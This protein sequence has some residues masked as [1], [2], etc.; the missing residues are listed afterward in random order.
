[1]IFNATKIAAGTSLLGAGGLAGVLLAPKPAE[2]ER[3]AGAL[4]A[5]A[6]VVR[7]VHIK[8]VHHRVIHEKPKRVHHAAPAAPAPAPVAA[9]TAAPA[10]IRPV[11]PAPAPAPTRQPLRTRTSGSA[12]TGESE[13]E[14]EGGEHGGGD[15]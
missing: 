5:P 9:A 8:R 10:P 12:T 11:A 7:T 15:D 14:H 2:S 4:P 6:P 1:M 3:A 13:H